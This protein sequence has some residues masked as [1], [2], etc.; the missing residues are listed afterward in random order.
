MTYLMILLCV[1]TNA[2]WVGNMD[3]K[4]STSGE[5]FFLGGR[6]VSWLRKKQECTSQS[7]LEAVYVVTTNN[8]NQV[9]WMK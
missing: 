2:D 1:Y 6:L 4:K 5:A 9:I 8:C 7:T 3:E